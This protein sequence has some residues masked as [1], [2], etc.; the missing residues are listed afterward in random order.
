MKTSARVFS[1]PPGAPFLPTVADALI[2]GHL[3]PGFSFDGDPLKFAD[4]TI[5]VPT[6]RAAR[7]LRA[8]FAARMRSGSAILPTVRPLGEFDEDLAAFEGDSDTSLA[9]APPIAATDRLLM[10][11]PLVRAWKKRLPAHVAAL[12][13]EEVVV[14]TSAAD[15]IWLARD[16]ATLID[17]VETEGADWAKLA[18]LVEG[19]LSNWW[20]VTVDFL[21]IVTTGWPE[22]LRELDRSNPAAHR[23]A[24]ILA[25][26]ARLKRLPQSHPV[27]AAGSTGSIPAT[28]EL[29]SIIARLPNGA[30]VLPGLDASLDERS[31]SAINAPSPQPQ[32]CGH[33][34]YGLA[35]LIRGLGVQRSEILE[36]GNQSSALRIRGAL[37]SEAMRPAETSDAWSANRARLNDADLSEALSGVTLIE[38][39]TER[40][41]ALAAAVALRRAIAEPESRAALVTPDRELARRVAAELLRFGIKADD[42][43]GTPLTRT[44]PAELLTL[45]V[46]AAFRPGGPVPIAGLLKHP[47]L[48]LGL[49]RALV[50]RAAEAIELIVLRGSPARPDILTLDQ[51]F[52]SRLAALSVAVRTPFWLTRLSTSRIE[53]CR[54]VLRRL[55]EA[56]A[57]LQAYRSAGEAQLNDILTTTVKSFDALGR[58]PSSSLDELYK[59]D[60]GEK[61]ADVLR[62]LAGTSARFDF[63]AADW[64][65]VLAALLAPEIVKPARGGD[66]RIAIWGTLE[67]RLQTVDT[68]VVSGLNEGS[69]PRRAEAD[70]FMSRMMKGGLELEPPERRIGLAAHDFI[71]AMGAQ[72]I[73]LTR[74][75]R[76]GDAPATPS[77]W[78]QRLTTFIGEDHANAIRARGG[79]VIAWARMLDTGVTARRFSRPDPKPPLE[80]RPKSF[81]VTDIEKLR[82][83]PY[84]IY[85]RKILDLNPL[86]QLV[87]DPGASE[88][89]TLFHEILKR[90]TQTC[91]DPTVLDAEAALLAAA[92]AVFAEAALPPDVHAVW[93]PRFMALATGAEG[94][95]NWE[96]ERAANVKS[97]HAEVRA[98]AT[99]VGKTGTTLSGFADRIDILAGGMADILDY[100]TGSTPSKAQAHTLIAPQLALEGALLAREG[101]KEIGAR[102]PSQLAHVRLKANG[103]VEEESILELPRKPAKSARQLSEE[104]WRRL[105]ELL[106][107]YRDLSRGYISRALPFKE[108]DT[109]GDYD[110]LARVLEWSAGGETDEFA[111]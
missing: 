48:Q 52:E 28:A 98:I 87:R 102:E 86:E 2:D 103:R 61:L 49:D 26:A 77:R 20:Q 76:A 88:R 3:V 7:E 40:E 99:A 38:A 1:I 107:A 53:E 91:P 24:L 36:I 9:L 82:R 47:L 79:E 65:E 95:L 46:E 32:L 35:K 73:V 54:K 33:P 78:L 90:F 14:P 29:L 64:P 39:A 101:F 5:F 83:D 104:A 92:R 97:R 71:M 41:E 94:L 43:G 42:S 111:E 22:I 58:S 68:L 72:K 51:L 69:W 34:Q 23:S 81:S 18:S 105:D 59:G 62:T 8:V 66:G 60:A 19:N 80:V 16:L 67:A 31:W 108:G 100:K 45:L 84:A 15:S 57:P 70:R 25:E 93:W 37:V 10:L 6:R 56:I 12:F 50:R 63:P 44:P 96:R 85:A 55:V 17:E 109:D 21:Q 110:H 106:T 4:V 11:A 89:G 13:E 27:I 74:A 75:A 30:V